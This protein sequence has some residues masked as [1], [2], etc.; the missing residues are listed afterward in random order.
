MKRLMIFFLFFQILLFSPALFAQEVR[1]V[2]LKGEVF[3][4][5][6]RTLLWQKAKE[7]M[8]LKKAA[9]IKTDKD[10]ECT[11]AFDNQLNNAIT[12]KEN[13]HLKIKDIIP[14]KIDL[15]EGRIFALIEDIGAVKNFEIVTP[16]AVTGVRGTGW[17]TEYRKG[18]TL[19]SCFENYIYAQGR[20]KKGKLTGE[21]EIPQ[22]FGINIG[23][24]GIFGDIYGLR[25][26]DFQEWRQTKAKLKNIR[27]RLEAE[28]MEDFHPLGDFREEE[29]ENLLQQREEIQEQGGG[30]RLDVY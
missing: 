12:V 18:R 20:D 23:P 29:L 13:S 8:L 25:G 14:A 21:K 3:V 7:D 27:E 10:S 6:K 5:R 9:E 30:Y 11:L 1:V 2:D 19:L 17:S 24:G 22:G 15:P 4:K 26:R 28:R 16:S